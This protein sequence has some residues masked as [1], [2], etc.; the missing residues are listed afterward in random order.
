MYVWST[1]SFAGANFSIL[2]G[3]HH[4]HLHY[5]ATYFSLILGIQCLLYL[6][7]TK[8]TILLLLLVR[9]LPCNIKLIIVLMTCSC[10]SYYCFVVIWFLFTT[11]NFRFHFIFFLN[12]PSPC[13][14]ATFLLRY[15]VTLSIVLLP[16]LFQTLRWHLREHLRHLSFLTVNL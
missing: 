9:Q 5:F 14:L 12:G 3:W 8:P 6:I 10:F 2:R 7:V 16:S 4:H 13:C 15:P 1:L 11:I